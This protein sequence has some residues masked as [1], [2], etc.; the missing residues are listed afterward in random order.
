[1]AVMGYDVFDDEAPQT[2]AGLQRYVNLAG[3]VISVSLI[4]GV[5]F[6]GYRLAVRDVTGIPVVRAL[7]GPMRIAPE[8]P[9]G[10]LASHQGLA[11]NAV[12]AEGEAAPPPDRLVLAPQPLDLTSED[13][14]PAALQPILRDPAQIAEAVNAEGI[15]TEA[16]VEDL[17]A[18]ALGVEEAQGLA[19]AL[20]QEL[21]TAASDTAPVVTEEPAASPAP[22]TATAVAYSPRPAARPAR[23]ATASA[24]L[25]SA[26]VAAPAPSAAPV[27]DISADSLPAGTN[28]VQLGAFDDAASA[29]RE[30]D[31]L[32][33]RF[34]AYLQGKARVIQ[35]AESGGRTFYRLRAHGFS[36][37]AD[38]RRFC[39]ALLA[40]QAACIPV[41][42]R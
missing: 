18:P 41:Q 28:L 37:D 29:R 38:A 35:T 7:E 20:A 33:G 9:G 31:R 17:S 22:A 2:G 8:D 23:V 19:L 10:R 40:E 36:D 11:V 14:P 26:A 21:A 34:P 32:S 27:Q 13:V 12:A 15:A 42:I 6:W 25:A 16:L 3:A 24:T 39:S 5:A 30:W 4:L 1:M